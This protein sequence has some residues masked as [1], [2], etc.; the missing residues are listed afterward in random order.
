MYPPVD[1]DFYAI[2]S[3]SG[4]SDEEIQ[5]DWQAYCD[6][7]AK[8]HK[9]LDSAMQQTSPEQVETLEQE[10]LIDDLKKLFKEPNQNG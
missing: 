7:L 9:D 3:N 8:F 10:P 5:A 4:M 1:P 6:D 2:G